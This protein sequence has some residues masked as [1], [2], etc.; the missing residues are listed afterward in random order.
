MSRNNHREL[1]TNLYESKGYFRYRHPVTKKWFHLGNNRETAIKEANQ[2]N[3]ILSYRSKKVEE[4]LNSEQSKNFG[5]FIEYFIENILPFQNLAQ[6][7][8]KNYLQRIANIKKHLGHFSIEKINTKNLSEFF[9]QYPTNQSNYYRA[10][11]SVIFKHAMA[12]GFTDKNPAAATLKKTVTK[13][14][15]RLPLEHFETIRSHA[16]EWLKNAM[17]LALI[18]G[19]RRKDIAALKWTDIH[20]GFIWIQQHKTHNRIKINLSENLKVLLIKCS[21]EN[22]FVIGEIKG[23]ED[24]ITKAFAEARE[25]SG[26]KTNATFHEIRSLSGYLYEQAGIEKREIQ[27]LFGHSSEKMTEHYLEGHEEKWTEIITTN[28][29]L[30]KR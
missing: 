21:K 28:T 1:P 22:E 25:K 7:T 30:I 23:N 2:L 10:V 27:M 5:E 3:I 14:R 24:K 17:D 18:T 8:I 11:L 26:L 29:T 13:Q 9:N 4:I 20:D 12:E 15:L 6:E 19:Q 16:P